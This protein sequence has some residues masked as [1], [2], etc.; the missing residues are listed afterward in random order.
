MLYTCDSVSHLQA[1]AVHQPSAYKPRF[2][3]VYVTLASSKLPAVRPNC[4]WYMQVESFR[5]TSA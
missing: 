3:W 5:V 1:V 4:G 2:V